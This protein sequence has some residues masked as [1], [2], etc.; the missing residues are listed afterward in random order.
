MSS[1]KEKITVSAR[2]SLP[3]DKVWELWTSPGHIIRWNHASEDW[4]T[5]FAENN[6]APGGKFLFR[7]E[8]KDGSFGFDFNGVYNSVQKNKFIGYN[9]GDEREVSIVFASHG[10]ETEITETF[11]PE[12][13]N[14]IEMQRSGWQSI[15]N[16]FKKYAES[17]E[18]GLT[19]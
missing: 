9:L 15:L 18:V 10:N 2:V 12:Q 8:A 16:N 4:H 6:L 5:P 13:T 14:P 17:A 3:V 7:M 1:R 11:D 19:E